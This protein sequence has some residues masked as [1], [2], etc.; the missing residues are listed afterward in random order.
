MSGFDIGGAI[1]ASADWAC[2]APIIRTVVSNPVFTALLITALVVIV[3]MG[4]YSYR[5]KAAGTKRGIRAILYIF[6]LVMAVMFVHHY[7][8]MKIARDSEASRSVRDVFSSIDQSRANA[9]YGGVA[10]VY[11]GVWAPAAQPATTGGGDCGCPEAPAE[12]SAA[13]SGATSAARQ[14][15][16]RPDNVE[17]EG[18]IVIEDVTV[19]M[20]APLGRR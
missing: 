4:L 9:A 7:A 19:P 3:I 12:A 15:S 2:N 8:V 1:N 18:G 14:P 11:P 6:M 20:A 10:P 5:V 17:F 16:S 13:A